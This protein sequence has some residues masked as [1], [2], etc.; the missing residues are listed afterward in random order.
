MGDS[1]GC[2]ENSSVCV[3][4]WGG[5]AKGVWVIAVGV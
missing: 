2:V 1:S 3:C 4:V 5:T